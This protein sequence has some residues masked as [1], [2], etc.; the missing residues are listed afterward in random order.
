MDSLGCSETFLESPFRLY[1]G[2]P[3]LLKASYVQTGSPSCKGDGR[4]R[5]KVLWVRP[6]DG[7]HKVERLVDMFR[8]ETMV[9]V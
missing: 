8:Y 2:D 5:K 1:T 6:S 7:F 4:E 9:F 3:E